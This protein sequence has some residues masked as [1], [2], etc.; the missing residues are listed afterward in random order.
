MW[1]LLFL[2]IDEHQCNECKRSFKT[3]QV[4]LNHHKHFHD[5]VVCH[6][7][8]KTLRN[9]H[10]PFH[11]NSVH[12]KIIRFKCTECDRGYYLNSD[13]QDHIKLMHNSNKPEKCDQCAFS[14]HYPS[15]LKLHILQKH[16]GKPA[17]FKCK[18]CSSG[19]FTENTL[20]SHMLQHGPKNYECLIEEC[21]WKFYTRAHLINHGKKVH[22]MDFS[23]DAPKIK[24]KR[25]KKCKDNK[26][27]KRRKSQTNIKEED[28]E[29]QAEVV[30]E[31]YAMEV[32]Y[33]EEEFPQTTDVIKH[34]NIN[35]DNNLFLNEYE[36]VEVLEN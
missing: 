31:L 16:E 27:T 26:A 10:L 25:S 5:N 8:G 34:E 21:D 33:L 18:E 20:R 4:L 23:N 11:I 35:T 28:S 15:R 6:I 29:F 12:K 2:V 13:L 19:F 3:E 32:E 1:D 24:R 9:R 30:D 14:C 7:C 36:N 22:K 17:P